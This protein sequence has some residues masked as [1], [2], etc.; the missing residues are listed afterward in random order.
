MSKKKTPIDKLEA[1]VAEIEHALSEAFMV[2]SHHQ[3]FFEHIAGIIQEEQEQQLQ[4]RGISKAD[5]Q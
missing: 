2:M 4:E 1:R 3:Q 5:D